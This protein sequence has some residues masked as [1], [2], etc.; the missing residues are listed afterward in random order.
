MWSN[1]VKKND[2]K[3]K[4]KVEKKIIKKIKKDNF[5][6]FYNTDTEFDFKYNSN[7]MDIIEDFENMI[8]KNNFPVK[9]RDNLNKPSLYDFI[10]YNSIE[11]LEIEDNVCKMNKEYN[12]DD[13]EEKSDDDYE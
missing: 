13:I 2:K 11:L 4:K 6:E 1:I 10:K 12:D 3:I 8:E 5:I 7:I 9:I